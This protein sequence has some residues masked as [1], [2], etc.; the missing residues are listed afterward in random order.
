MTDRFNLRKAKADGHKTQPI[1]SDFYHTRI[2]QVAE[3]GLQRGYN[4]DDDPK[5]QT[6]FAFQ[7]TDGRVITKLMNQVIAPHSNLGRLTAALPDV[8]DIPEFLGQMVDLELEANG[9]WPKIVG[10]SNPEDGL[11]KT[12]EF[13]EVELLLYDVEVDGPEVLKKLDR[14]LRQAVSQRIRYKADAGVEHDII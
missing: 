12:G 14:N 11:G 4:S 8:D 2:I 13:P 7:L 6:G 1:A 5:P 9:N 10:I 3:V